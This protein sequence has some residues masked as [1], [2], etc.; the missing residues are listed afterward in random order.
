MAGTTGLEPA[1]SAMTGY[2]DLE[3]QALTG[4]VEERKV[5][6]THS[7]EFLS[8]LDCSRVGSENQIGGRIGPTLRIIGPFEV[9]VRFE[10]RPSSHESKTQ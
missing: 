4:Y 7:R 9:S 1:A 3:I 2:R 6:K 5:L 10:L 8:F